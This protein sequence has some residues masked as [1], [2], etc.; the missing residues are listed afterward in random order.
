MITQLG[1][2]AFAVK[3]LDAARK[4]YCRGLGLEEAFHLC[5]DDGSLW[6]VY[7]KVGNG[8]FLE[9]F[10]EPELQAEEAVVSYKHTCLVVDD[11]A[12]FVA[13]LRARGVSLTSEVNRGKDG[14]LQAWTRDPDGNRIEL[15]EIAPDSQQAQ[16]QGP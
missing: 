15:M 13:G 2:V 14:N 16:A 3:D 12:A 8:S 9:L 1:H 5:R 6:I 10:P 7:L 11:L 4:F